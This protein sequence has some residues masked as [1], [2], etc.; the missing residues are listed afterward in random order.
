MI[1]ECSTGE[2]PTRAAFIDK[3]HDVLKHYA[4]FKGLMIMNPPDRL[5]ADKTIFLP[6]IYIPAI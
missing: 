2:L 3:G 4:A 5:T 1:L 6:E